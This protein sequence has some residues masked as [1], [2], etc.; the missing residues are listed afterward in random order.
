[1][2]SRG[3]QARDTYKEGKPQPSW[4]V[5]ELWQAIKAER[6]AEPH[7]FLQQEEARASQGSSSTS[8]LGRGGANF[9]KRESV[10]YRLNIIKNFHKL[11]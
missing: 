7:K 1:M 10:S 11:K 8:H 5:D 4:C 6:N 2:S 9:L 3:S